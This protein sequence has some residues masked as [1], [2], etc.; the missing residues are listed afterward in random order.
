MLSPISGNTISVKPETYKAPHQ[1]TGPKKY[2]E[3]D[4][5]FFI[6]KTEINDT[7]IININ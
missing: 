6:I 5:I 1:I 7:T 2:G 3:G 4:L